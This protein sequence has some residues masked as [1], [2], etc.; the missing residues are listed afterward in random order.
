MLEPV[1]AVGAV[2]QRVEVAASAPVLETDSAA[3]VSTLK[4]PSHL[5]VAAS[6]SLGKRILSLDGAG[7][8]FLSRNAGKSWKKVLPEW[9]GKAVNIDLTAA[10]A[11]EAKNKS[12]ASGRT[13]ALSI[14]RL[15][16]DSG[17]QWTSNDGTHWRPQ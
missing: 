12:Q 10:E 9:T 14:F 1:L 15:T 6:V 17:A 16:T 11:S 13:S 7:N 3:V 4:L 8:L 2:T 5:P